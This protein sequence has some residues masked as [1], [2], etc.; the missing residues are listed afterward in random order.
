MG[1]K[2]TPIF[3]AF[4][5]PVSFINLFQCIWISSHYLGKN[6]QRWT[7]MIEIKR[8]LLSIK[9]HTHCAEVMVKKK[10]TAFF[11]EMQENSQ[12]LKKINI[13]CIF[14]ILKY[15]FDFFESEKSIL[16]IKLLFWIW[17]L[18]WK[19]HTMCGNWDT[20]WIL[21]KN[22]CTWK[23]LIQAFHLLKRRYLTHL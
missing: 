6:P 7:I 9:A 19:L 18:F 23:V 17:A 21:L 3:R 20:F 11:I 14:I 1:R 16:K 4:R 13:L 12:T 2:W 22:L 15:L 10:K 8:A 5:L